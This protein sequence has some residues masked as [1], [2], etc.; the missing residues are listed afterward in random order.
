MEIQIYS[1]PSQEI[2]DQLFE[3]VQ[4]CHVIDGT[5][6]F[7]YLDNAY[8]FDGYMPAFFLANLDHQTVGF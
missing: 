8:N 4:N 5:Y 3:L 1:Q 2:K 7:P 6:R